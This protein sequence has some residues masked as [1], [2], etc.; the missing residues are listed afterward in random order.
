MWYPNK[1][2]DQRSSFPKPRGLYWSM[3][4]VSTWPACC[5]KD[6]EVS[7]TNLNVHQSKA[8]PASRNNHSTVVLGLHILPDLLSHAPSY[9]LLFV[10]SR[11]FSGS[12]RQSQCQYPYV[13][14]AGLRK[15]LYNAQSMD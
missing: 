6:E 14:V 7:S 9:G 10:L 4:P 12:I 5:L 15:A 1:S 8:N 3:M 13:L 2:L 11:R